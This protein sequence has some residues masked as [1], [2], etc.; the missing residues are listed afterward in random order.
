[1]ASN[2]DTPKSPTPAATTVLSLAQAILAPLDALF[3]AQIHASRSFVNLLGQLAYPHVPVDKDGNPVKK[4][5][6]V[7]LKD[8]STLVLGQDKTKPYYFPFNIESIGAEGKR[9]VHQIQVP[10]ITLVPIQPLG[11]SEAEIRFSM[12]ISEVA[13]HKQIQGSSSAATESEDGAASAERRPWY[14][15]DNPVSLRGTVANAP[16]GED[17]VRASH[18]SNFEITI[19]LAKAPV[20]AALEKA[21]TM[22]TQ[23]I[24][25]ETPPPAG[26]TADPTAK[27]S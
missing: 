8:R 14:L 20:P 5:Q 27:D 15:V 9:V 18:S 2:T 12:S 24:H 16:P 25:L 4:D 22:L 13:D 11:I 3:K 19:K 21:L 10:T 23:T 26:D 1:M 7:T 17:S 6:T